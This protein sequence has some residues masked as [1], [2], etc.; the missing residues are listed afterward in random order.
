MAI[1]SLF[2]FLEDVNFWVLGKTLGARNCSPGG[3]SEVKFGRG[4]IM[5]GYSADLT[6]SASR[7][8]F[9]SHLCRASE[10]SALE[11]QKMRP[12]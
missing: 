3:G 6:N 9:K 10:C 2:S 7:A 11:M 8:E 1:A 12:Y 5:E 4:C